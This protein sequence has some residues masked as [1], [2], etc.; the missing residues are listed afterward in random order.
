MSRAELAEAV[1]AWLWQTTRTRYDLDGHYVAKLERGLVTW[2]TAP[3]RSGLR[4]VLGATSDAE[5]GFRSSRGRSALVTPS[6]KAMATAEDIESP[7]PTSPAI[8]ELCTVLTDPTTCLDRFAS[9][10]HDEAPSIGKLTSD[11]NLAFT[12][13]QQ[14]RFTTAATRTST[15]LADAWLASRDCDHADRAEV[16]SVLALSHQVA[17]SVLV[18]AG[19]SDI[20]W[21][22]AERGMDAARATDNPAVKGS[23]I[24]S[25]AFSL[26]A[27]GRLEPAMRLVD[28]GAIDLQ[29]HIG[30]DDTRLSVYGTLLLVGSLAAARFGDRYKA[31]DYLNEADDAARRLGRDA[32]HLWTAFGPTNVAIHRVNAAAELGDIQTVLDTGLALNT[33]AVLVERRARYLLDVARAHSIVGD[34]DNAMS[35]MLAAERIAPEQVRQHHL[36]KR[37]VMTL[38]RNTVG[39]PS[40]DLDKLAERVNVLGSV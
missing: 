5:L 4:H 37:V 13:Y 9:V 12:A 34:R 28:S 20:A 8:A 23:L 38:V 33:D 25:I 36:S 14:A 11:L 26:L 10:Q 35:T 7:H 1:C 22:A 15:L 6:I 17:A 24:R 27:T 21:I 39:K 3:Y 16:F 31:A 32:N 18:K 29:D 40:V 2:P 30:G 19:E